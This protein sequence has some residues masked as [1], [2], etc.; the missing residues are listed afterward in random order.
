MIRSI[1]AL[2]LL[3]IF[4]RISAQQKVLVKQE[5]MKIMNNSSEYR[6]FSFAQGDVVQIDIKVHD[7]LFIKDVTFGAFDSIPI[8][9]IDSVSVIQHM[10]ILIP[11]EGFYY[12]KF[13]HEGL[14]EGKRMADIVISRI[15]NST[16]TQNHTTN[17]AW[18]VV[19]DTTWHLIT[20]TLS[21]K[22]DTI[23]HML[24][25]QAI[26]LGHKKS[27][28][29]A[30]VSF[31]LPETSVNWGYFIATGND[32]DMQYNALSE[33]ISATSPVAEKQGLLSYYLLGG[34]IPLVEKPENEKAFLSFT[35]SAFVKDHFI[36]DNS[37]ADQMR[38]KTSIRFGMGDTSAI[39]PHYALI[40]NPGKKKMIVWL[41]VGY[42]TIEMTYETNTRNTYSITTRNI[43][44]AL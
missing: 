13:T 33:S 19:N 34:N 21:I 31:M 16:K 30:V 8:K 23:S 18:K 27:D 42:T 37:S 17:V 11:H 41:Y 14:L 24:V 10:E 3:M 28:N 38:I 44:V 15:P 5:C 12:F 35:N 9:I 40:L 2:I 26:E 32:G 6:W 4:S 7:G 20:D 43:P 39:G 36:E 22:H 29:R 1:L 25:M